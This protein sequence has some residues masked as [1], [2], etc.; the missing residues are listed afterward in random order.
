[1]FM[2]AFDRRKVDANDIAAWSMLPMIKKTSLQDAKEAFILYRSAGPDERGNKPYFDDIEMQRWLRQL[3]ANRA[4]VE[5]KARALR[6]CSGQKTLLDQYAETNVT[7]RM[8]MDIHG[9]SEEE[10]QRLEAQQVNLDRKA[11]EA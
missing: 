10:M 9:L 4:A 2:Q 7:R 6:Y 3:R 8:I 1:M 11:L 5:R